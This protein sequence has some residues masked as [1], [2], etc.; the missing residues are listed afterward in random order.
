MFKLR[1]EVTP[2]ASAFDPVDP[3]IFTD[4]LAV[5]LPEP[6][7]KLREVAAEPI[8]IVLAVA[9]PIVSV[10]AAPKAFIVVAVV[11]NKS[12]EVEGVVKEVVIDG[13]VVANVPFIVVVILLLPIVK[14]VA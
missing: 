12:N 5:K 3:A 9:A 10:V 6:C 14:L 4:L 2:V 11:F 7:P 13:L 8:D 1:V